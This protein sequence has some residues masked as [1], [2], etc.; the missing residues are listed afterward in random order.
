MRELSW[1]GDAPRPA[2]VEALRRAGWS[3]GETA[4]VV[5]VRSKTVPASPGALPW[6]W[7]TSSAPTAA[8]LK[9]AVERGAVDVF[10]T[11]RDWETR[12]L[13][14]LAELAVPE[15][16]VPAPPHVVAESAAARRMLR[17]IKQAAQ[18]SM[19][20]LLTGETGTGKELAARLIHEW[21]PR[22]RRTFVPITC[23]AI[24]DELM[25]GELFGYAKGAFSGAVRDYDGLMVAADG[26]TVFLD[27]VDD[28]PFSLQVKLLRVL[29]DHVVSRLGESKWRAVDF[30]VIAATNRDLRPLIHEGEFGAD[31]YE[32]LATVLIELP[33]LRDRLDDLPAMTAQL[34]ERYYRED[35]LAS[36]RG[37]VKDVTAEALEILKGYSWPGN[38]R[39][40]RNVVFAALVHKRTGSSL[41]PSDLP[42]RLWQE[43]RPDTDGQ[44]VVSTR[45]I[46]Q[47]LAEGSM[48]LKVEIEALERVAVE[49][50]LRRAA[51]SAAEAAR[52]LGEVGRG[53]AKDPGG[54]L[55]V[56][57]KRLGL[58][59]STR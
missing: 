5:V 46:E 42:R 23:A 12:L 9:T 21:S 40:L 7:L 18:T 22:S 1:R 49:A 34:I 51:G 52:M 10:P 16:P 50:A 27:E 58:S 54:T 59:G 14:R 37:V 11:E 4:E 57:M 53:T 17:Q 36:K 8:Q 3:V 44:T 20:V 31:F 45:A 43:S 13:A 29:E 33:P 56:M 28:T 32:R 47:K 6:L 38:V 24:P 41:L 35:P 26:G 19:P 25:E 48:N 2:L 15:T 55:R 39:E 30:R